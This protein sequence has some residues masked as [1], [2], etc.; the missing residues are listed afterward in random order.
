MKDF[1]GKKQSEDIFKLY[2]LSTN[3][4]SSDFTEN[5]GEEIFK[6]NKSAYE[7]STYI[8]QGQIQ[9]EMEDTLSAKLGN[10]LESDNDVNTSEEAIKRLNEAK[11]IYIKDRGKGGLID[12][13][14]ERLN[15][16]E[17]TLENSKSDE[18]TL[19]LKEIKLNEINSQIKEQEEVRDRNQ[20]LLS[21]KIEQ[22]RKIAKLETYSAIVNKF[23]QTKETLD[24]MEKIINNKFPGGL[25][26]IEEKI[27]TKQGEKDI[28]QKQV[29][30]HNKLSNIF[31]SLG[32]LLGIFSLI[33]IFANLQKIIGIVGISITLIFTITVIILNKNKNSKNQNIKDLT[34]DIQTLEEDREEAKAQLNLFNSILQQYEATKNEKEIF[35]R[36]NNIED[37]KKTNNAIE[38]SETELKEKSIE[39]NNKL[40]MLLDNKN[41]IKNQIEI[42][43]N[44]I[45]ENEYL[46]TDIEN[47]KEEIVNLNEKYGTLSKAEELLKTAKESFSSSYLQDMINGFN[48]YL[49][50]IDNE[51]MD[52]NVDINLDVKIDVN[53]M[54]KE[55][56][57]FSAGYKDLIYICMRFSLINALF[58]DE[59][60]FVVLDDPF[61]NLDEEKTK[62]ALDVL[63]EFSR[64]YQ[65]IYFVC[66]ESR[67]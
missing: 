64:E 26:Q 58:K 59:S 36:E 4:E 51:N 63:N 46:E 17:R 10:V 20:K 42:L 41:Q 5:I 24:N 28:L 39:I 50:V 30:T 62:K 56:K 32:V 38:I 48:K 53:G 3:L 43:E 27:K 9:I 45:D 18:E 1:F 21:E 8:P 37:L 52:T 34:K 15:R 23:N 47:L 40:D 33:L 35:E 11:K 14:K 12:E 54:Q 7:R 57:Y 66:N 6:M 29:K 19:K 16:L 60:P 61:V 2:D 65:I 13:K 49:K 55:I 25:E 44:Q 22:D 67:I 31:L